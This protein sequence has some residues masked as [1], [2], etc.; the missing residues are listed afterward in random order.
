MVVKTFEQTNPDDSD[1]IPEIEV[2]QETGKVKPRPYKQ[3]PYVPG[4]D[5]EG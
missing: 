5:Y 2:D 4:S 1:F 3:P